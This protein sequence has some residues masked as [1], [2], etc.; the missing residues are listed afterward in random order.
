MTMTCLK[1]PNDSCPF[2]DG[3]WSILKLLD[4]VNGSIS[5]FDPACMRVSVAV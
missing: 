4:I 3:I 1:A 5:I 2:G